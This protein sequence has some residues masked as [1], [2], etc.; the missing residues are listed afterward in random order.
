M[1]DANM[2]PSRGGVG[3]S[4]LPLSPQLTGWPTPSTLGQE[5]EMRV[6]HS[7]P[8]SPSLP[9]VDNQPVNP[10]GSPT[11]TSLSQ[12]EERWVSPS[13]PPSLPFPPIDDQLADANMNR[14]RRRRGRLVLSLSLSPID[15]LANPDHAWSRGGDAGKSLSYS[16]SLSPSG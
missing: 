11:P 7:P 10:T 6:S 14:S 12:E 2:N 1:A 5:E 3:E 16:L 9:P 13:P 15:R 8:L 4:S